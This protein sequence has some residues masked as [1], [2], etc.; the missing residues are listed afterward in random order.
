M[1][2]VTEAAEERD[3]TEILFTKSGMVIT[4]REKNMS[5][6]LICSN[7]EPSTWLRGHS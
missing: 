2:L 7:K 5:L 3:A 1:A 6:E 4:V